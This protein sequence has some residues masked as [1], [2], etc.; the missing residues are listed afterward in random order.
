MKLTL[1]NRRVFFIG[2]ASAIVAGTLAVPA[3]AA[4][5]APTAPAPVRSTIS[6]GLESAVS[7]LAAKSYGAEY[8]GMAVIGNQRQLA[9]YLTDPAPA[10][11]RAFNRIAPAGTLVFRKTPHSMRQLNVIQSRLQGKWRALRKSGIEVSEFGSNPLIGKVDVG[12]ENLT[13]SQAAKLDRIYGAPALHVFNVTPRQATAGRLAASRV[14]DT[15]PFNGGDAIMP[16]ARTFNCSTGFGVV[17]GGVSRLLTAGHC[18]TAGTRVYNGRSLGGTSFTGSNA[19]MGTVL[20]SAWR[21]GLDSG[22]VSG[23]G[24]DLIW[25]G[26]IGAPQRATVSGIGTWAV[27]DQVCTSGANG[28]EICGLTV[29]HVNYCMFLSGPIT[30]SYVCHITQVHGAREIAPGD[31]GGPVF[32]FSGSALKAVGTVSGFNTLGN[33]VSWFTGIYAIL[34]QWGATLRTG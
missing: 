20:E 21:S 25:T 16:A 7:N 30:L 22:V 33:G 3:A 19:P 24:S 27:G 26:P 13:A 1:L 9:V 23:P 4:L 2:A 28:G 34:G 32:R 8:G 5:G 12:V 31:S 29:Q 6:M 17:I 14:G 10:V 18:F 11:E 15:P